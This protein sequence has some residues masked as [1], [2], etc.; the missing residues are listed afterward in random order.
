[1]EKEKVNKNEVKK[2]R[3]TKAFIKVTGTK[4]K[5]YFVI[6]YHEIGKDY[7]NEG[8]GSYELNNVF[9][10]L[11]ECFEIVGVRDNG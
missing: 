10:W 2:I 7:D 3:V 6:I 11:E 9:D 4:E 5:P 8:F 1:M